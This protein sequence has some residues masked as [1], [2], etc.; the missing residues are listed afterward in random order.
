MSGGQAEGTVWLCGAR[1][2]DGGLS[3]AGLRPWKPGEKVGP[4]DA[5]IPNGGRAAFPAG[6]AEGAWLWNA[7]AEKAA[8][9]GAA[10]TARRLEREGFRTAFSDRKPR[11]GAA[12]ASARGGEL[13]GADAGLARAARAFAVTVFGLQAVEIDPRPEETKA[14]RELGRRLERASARAL[15]ALGLDM[16]TVKWEVDGRGR[17]GAVVEIGPALRPRAK[18]A[19]ARLAHAAASFAEAWRRET[20]V[21]ACAVL[22]ADPEF[23]LLSPRGK[24]VPA[25]RF[26][27]PGGAVGCD[28]VVIGGALRWP[29][30]ELRPAP[31]AEPRVLAARLRKLLAD[32]AKRTAGADVSFRAGAAPARGV[33][34]GGHLH[35]SGVALTGERL[36]ALDNAVALPLRLL[37]PPEAGRRRPRYGALGDFRPKPHG[38]FEYRVPPSWLVSPLLA[39]GTLALAKVAAE[40][41]RDL[42]PHRPLDDDAM[43]DAFYFGDR[44]MLLAGFERVRRAVMATSGYARYKDDIDPLFRAIAADKRWDESADLRDKWKIALAGGK[45]PLKPDRVR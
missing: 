13:R 2:T 43:R 27:A 9:L 30:A 18:E 17:Q 20:G 23:V 8:A 7:N 5:V 28:S 37:E 45:H 6:Q 44:P 10:E 40:H 38:G 4:R 15:Y 16:G 11:P 24:L 35:F 1:G 22:G 34:L 33:P 29:L 19:A 42:A 26:F 32:A 25:A 31:S 36:R 41:S 39:R 12:R 21:G 14:G 3:G